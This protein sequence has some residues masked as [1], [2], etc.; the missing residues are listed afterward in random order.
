MRICQVHYSVGLGGYLHRDLAAIKAGAKPNGAVFEG[1]P[2]SPGFR[3]IVEPAEIISVI[4][5][6]DD[7][8]IAFG[9]CVDVI[10]AGVGGRDPAFNAK[11]YL[12]L[13]QAEMTPLLA[14]RDVTHFRKN[15]EELDALQISG[16]PLHT[17]LRFGVTQALLHATALAGHKTMA[18]VVAAEYSTQLSDQ[19]IPL[20]VSC[21]RDDAG[22]RDRVILKRGGLFPHANFMSIDDHVGRRGEKLAAYAAGIARR[23]QEIGDADYRPRIHLDVYGTLGDLFPD[24]VDLA[25]Y[26]ATLAAAAAP[27]DLIV[28][29]PIIAESRAGQLA[30]YAELRK[31]I[32]DKRA[33]VAIIVDEWCN[34]LADV[35]DFCDARVADYIQVKVPDLGGINNAIEAAN[36]CRANGTG[37][38]LG[39]S[40]NETDQSARITAHIALACQ[41]DFILSKPGLGGDEGMMILTNEMSRSLVLVQARRTQQEA[42]ANPAAEPAI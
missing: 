8:Q 35:V 21:Q 25:G 30:R 23:I 10:L 11:D 22:Q 13:M 38:C 26:L 4:L 15:A 12:G 32:A 7:G 20:L 6:L 42:S 34:T 16:K 2:I 19:P 17:A 41:P 9:D 33:P 39:G 1:Q 31:A 18:E 29:S 40:A 3:K 37:V 5:V 36:Y 14:G 27:Y 28:E 24:P